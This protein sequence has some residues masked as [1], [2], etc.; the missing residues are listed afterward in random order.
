[1]R[2]LSVKVLKNKLSKYV[3]LAADGETILITDRDRVVA[4]LTAPAP[5]RGMSVDDAALAELVRTGCLTPPLLGPGG[6]VPRRPVARLAV[7]LQ[8]LNS[9]RADR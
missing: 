6:E 8:E 7:L 4:Q 3:R 2:A 1:M 5:V 9:D